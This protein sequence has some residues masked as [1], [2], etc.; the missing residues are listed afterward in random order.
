VGA[1]RNNGLGTGLLAAGLVT[2]GF[3]AYYLLTGESDEVRT[4]VQ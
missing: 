3:A 1:F 2:T 4:G